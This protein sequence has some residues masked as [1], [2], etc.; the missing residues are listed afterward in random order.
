MAHKG[1]GKKNSRRGG[2]NGKTRPKN[3]TIKPPSS[4]LAICMKIQEGH[5]F[6][7]VDAHYGASILQY[8]H[9]TYLETKAAAAAKVANQC[10]SKFT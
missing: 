5:D 2:E 7:A 4:A 10:L 1:V 8:L 3:R 9:I 6:S